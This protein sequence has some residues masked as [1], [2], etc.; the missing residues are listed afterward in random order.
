MF[1]EVKDAQCRRLCVIASYNTG[2]GNVSRAFIGTT[3]ISNAY[4]EINKLDY[5]KLY[6]HLT[7]KL[8]TAEARNY[9]K[10]VTKKREKYI[11]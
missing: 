10:G 4:N 11:K 7:N 8:S 9:V 2:A 6:H 5:T 1:D 3:R